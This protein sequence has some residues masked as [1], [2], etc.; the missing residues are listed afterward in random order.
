MHK[1]EEIWAMWWRETMACLRQWQEKLATSSGRKQKKTDLKFNLNDT[2]YQLD[3]RV[4]SIQE[5]DLESEM[6]NCS[7]KR[8]DW[9]QCGEPKR[10]RPCQD[11]SKSNFTAEINIL[12][13]QRKSILVSTAS[14]KTAV[15]GLVFLQHHRVD[16]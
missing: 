8:V 6:S 7:Y 13:T 1:Q 12:Q 10:Q 15:W 4:G 14:F 5:S 2:V 9:S 3:H 16:F 11:G